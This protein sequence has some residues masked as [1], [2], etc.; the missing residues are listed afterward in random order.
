MVDLY[1]AENVWIKKVEEIFFV[2]LELPKLFKTD[3]L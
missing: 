2:D 3:L 1:G